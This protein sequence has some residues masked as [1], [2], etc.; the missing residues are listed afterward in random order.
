MKK[1]LSF[2]LTL[3]IIICAV[4]MGAFT[5]TV[6][7]ATTGTTGDCTWV[8]DG[9]VLTISGNGKTG[10]Y[11]NQY[12]LT[13]F[14]KNKAEITKVIIES[15]VTGIGVRTFRDC[16]NLKDIIIPDSVTSI[17]DYAFYGCE[18][19]ANITIP[20]SVTT[21]GDNAFYYSGITDITIPNSVINMGERVFFG[22]YSLTNATIGDSV[23]SIGYRAF[24]GCRTLTGVSIGDCVTSI[25]NEAFYDCESLANITIPDSVTTIGDNAFCGCTGLTSVTIPDSVTGIGN[26]AFYRCTNLNYVCYTGI[27]KDKNLISIGNCNEE[28]INATWHYNSCIGLSEHKYSDFNVCTVCNYNKIFEYITYKI[29]Y[30]DYTVTITDCDTSISGKYVLPS[31]I[32]DKP[33]EKVGDSAFADCTKLT[34]VEI[35]RS[36]K[37]IGSYAFSNSGLVSFYTQAQMPYYAV[38]I[39]QGAF[40]GCKKLSW[41]FLENGVTVGANA[42]YNCT[43]LNSIYLGQGTLSFDGS[44]DNSA[45]T[46]VNATVY[47]LK[48]TTVDYDIKNSLGKLFT[49]KVI[50]NGVC[51]SNLFWQFDEATKTLTISGTGN[52]SEY[53]SGSQTPW[54][55]YAKDIETIVIP[56]GI[57]YIPSY[58]FE[59]QTNVKTVRLPNTLKMLALNAFNDCENLNNLIIPSTLTNIDSNTSFNRCGSFT[60]IYY[61]GTKEDFKKITNNN[62]VYS[63]SDNRTVNY[64]VYHEKTEPTCTKNGNEAYY[65]FEGSVINNIYDC[66]KNKIKEIPLISA[67]GHDAST[68]V[69][70]NRIEP[71][72]TKGGSY[73]SVIYCTVCDEEISRETTIIPMRE[74]SFGEVTFIKPAYKTEGYSTHTC[75]VCG[76]EERFDFIDALTYISGD[77]NDDEAVNNRDLG[78]LMRWLNGW[79]IELN[80]LAADVDRD[81]F[82]NNRDYGVLMRYLNG[83]EIELK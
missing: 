2:C 18:N 20:D 57:T 66:D 28:L 42:F 25:G 56:D 3:A 50:D 80:P 53:N 29:S 41:I 79:D 38:K 51:G 17:G 55:V 69:I 35:P 68:T 60:D 27:E 4:P 75:T 24:Y 14:G 30:S 9:T 47:Y 64:L 43:N 16:T 1:L 54:Y 76:Y 36:V 63:Y 22:C 58:V 11:D 21:I 13:P 26:Y 72:C 23:K 7:A 19:L 15:G 6:D 10:D 59:Y 74:H 44:I 83:W 37:E 70:E 73:D 40:S 62:L 61:V 52:F 32:D 71:T 33:V 65:S 77:M 78:V 39:G 82:V 67:Y 46:N 49:F 48:N 81:G 31:K 45:F 5:L 12:N 8:L 34:N